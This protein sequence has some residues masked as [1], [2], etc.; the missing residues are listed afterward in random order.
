MN[1]FKKFFTVLI[2]VLIMI[3][4][5]SINVFA[6]NV[7]TVVDGKSVL[8][9][10]EPVVSNG[11]VYVSLE[12]FAMNALEIKDITYGASYNQVEILTNEFKAVNFDKAQKSIELYKI[13]NNT[14]NKIIL[15]EPYRFL[16]YGNNVLVSLDTIEACF[17]CTVRYNPEQQKIKVNKNG[18]S[19]CVSNNFDSEEIFLNAGEK[20]Y[21]NISGL[22]YNANLKYAVVDM[23]NNTVLINYGVTFDAVSKCVTAVN[24]GDYGLIISYSDFDTPYAEHSGEKI[25]V[26]TGVYA[27]LIHVNGNTIP[28]YMKTSNLPVGTVQSEK[29]I[30]L[31]SADGRIRYT[32][33]SEV[34]A[35]K[36]VGWYE[37]CPIVGKTVWIN[38]LCLPYSDFPYDS[39]YMS[40]RTVWKLDTISGFNADNLE[41]INDNQYKIKE[42]Y[43]W[44]DNK[45]VA[46]NSD[47]LFTGEDYRINSYCIASWDNPRNVY[48]LSDDE[49]NGIQNGKVWVGMS[50]TAF[51]LLGYTMPDAVNS[52]NTIYGVY[53]EYTYKFN[54]L[55]D[56]YYFLNGYLTKFNINY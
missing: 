54:Y 11:I 12:D 37:S 44:E 53:E 40:K 1:K 45:R 51:Q 19:F 43:F 18:Y 13:G 7:R 56:T 36:K 33:E 31:Y 52:R 28:D 42:F 16:T 23:A 21:F 17:D 34:E 10:T 8:L 2:M 5:A 24:S 48:K 55:W 15:N 6:E 26:D 27:I 20:A 29:T 25:P 46:I 49:W 30:P 35:Y 22:D 39:E 32:L 14:I 9:T 50:K 41:K 47:I 4:S 38:D 3:P